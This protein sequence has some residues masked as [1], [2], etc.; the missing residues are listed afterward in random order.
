[1]TSRIN[2]QTKKA[3]KRF[4]GERDSFAIH[5]LSK[6]AIFGGLVSEYIICNNNNI[7]IYNNSSSTSITG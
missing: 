7:G 4:N 2:K 3:L 6:E 1:M 5:T